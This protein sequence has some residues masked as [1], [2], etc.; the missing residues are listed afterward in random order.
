[1]KVLAPQ[2]SY[3]KGSLAGFEKEV[4]RGLRVL[5]SEDGTRD[6][7]MDF[8]FEQFHRDF[9]PTCKTGSRREIMNCRQAL[10]DVAEA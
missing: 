4:N 8:Q 6:L 1:L 7:T 10:Y 9:D 2:R 3:S 5:T